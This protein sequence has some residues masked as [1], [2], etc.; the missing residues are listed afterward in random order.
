MCQREVSSRSARAMKLQNGCWCWLQYRPLERSTQQHVRICKDAG[1]LLLETS[2]DEMTVV[3]VEES[4]LVIHHPIAVSYN[5][6]CEDYAAERK[7]GTEWIGSAPNVC[8]LDLTKNW[9]ACGW[10]GAQIER[11]ECLVLVWEQF[12]HC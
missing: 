4:Q 8:C 10:D 9:S 2:L 7:S 1:H 3:R 6:Q 12:V 5:G 11:A